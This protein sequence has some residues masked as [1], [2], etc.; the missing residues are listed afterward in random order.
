MKLSVIIPTFGRDGIFVRTLASVKAA[1]EGTDS[2]IIVVNDSE[3]ELDVKSEGNLYVMRN[4]GKGAAAARNAGVARARGDLLLFID[5][6]VIVSRANILRV[7]E[8]HRQY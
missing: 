7:L 1:L 3:K 4:P 6:D 8:L 2:E 5:N